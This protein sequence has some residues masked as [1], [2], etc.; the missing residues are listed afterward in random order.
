ML[1][2]RINIRWLLVG[3]PLLYQYGLVCLLQNINFHLID[4]IIATLPQFYC[5]CR[6]YGEMEGRGV[7]TFAS[8]QRYEGKENMAKRN[9]IVYSVKLLLLLRRNLTQKC[10]KPFQGCLDE[11]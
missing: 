4:R 7:C 1:T 8:G 3:L 9:C 11:A 5:S 2:K 10:T 6:A